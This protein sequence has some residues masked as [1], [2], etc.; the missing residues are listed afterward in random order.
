M[1][2]LKNIQASK[3]MNR[4]SNNCFTEQRDRGADEDLWRADR[5]DG[6]EL[7]T[8]HRSQAKISQRRGVVVE[9]EADQ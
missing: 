6:E 3:C 8:I 4:N 9:N 7:A 2:S 5:Q 1:K